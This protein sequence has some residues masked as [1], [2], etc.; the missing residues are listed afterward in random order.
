MWLLLSASSEAPVKADFI[1]STLRLT[2]RKSSQNKVAASLG[3]SPTCS[4]SDLLRI[5]LTA[6]ELRYLTQVELKYLKQICFNK[7][8]AELE[9]VRGKETRK[10]SFGGAESLKR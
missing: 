10:Q 3:L 1:S 9:L 5:R 8:K 7:L 4:S 2:K 6:I